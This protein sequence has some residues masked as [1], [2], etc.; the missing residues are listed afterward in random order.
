MQDPIKV[1]YIAGRGHSG[2]TLLDLLIGSHS[3]VVGLGEMRHL[4]APDPSLCSCARGVRVRDCPFWAEVAARVAEDSRLDL[5]ALDLESREPDVFRRHNRA[6]LEAVAAVSGRRFIVDSSKQAGRLRMLMESG[7][8]DVFP[9][10]LLRQPHGVVWSH[11]R[12][13]RSWLAHSWVHAPILFETRRAV[14]G[15]NYLVVR[16][17]ELAADPARELARIMAWIGL[18]FE[19][20]QLDWTGVTRHGVGGNDMRFS[21]DGVIRPD[22]AWRAGLSPL[23][24]AAISLLSAPAALPDAVVLPLYRALQRFRRRR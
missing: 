23:Q 12:R 4:N 16:Y 10:H 22:M 11:A 19:R 2:S 3:R 5:W 20:E 18:P 6:L 9:I 1:I 17:E 24:K 21:A 8:A 7:V 13:G 14:H 15:K